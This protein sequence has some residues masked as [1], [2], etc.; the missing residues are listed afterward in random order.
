MAKDLVAG[1]SVQSGSPRGECF[2]GSAIHGGT[3]QGRTFYCKRTRHPVESIG[4]DINNVM[5]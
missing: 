2:E 4:N 1:A 5:V 3:F